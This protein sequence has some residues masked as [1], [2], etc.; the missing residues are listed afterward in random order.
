M[1]VFILLTSILIL[2]SCGMSDKERMEIATITCNVMAESR[3]MDAAFRIKELNSARE[4]LGEDRFLEGDDVIKQAFQFGLC[5]ELVLNDPR[6]KDLLEISI[7]NY[8]NEYKKVQDSILVEKQKELDS[9]TKINEELARKREKR[10]KQYRIERSASQKEWR[11]KIVDYL[12]DYTPSTI[13]NLRYDPKLERL[14]LNFA[15]SEKTKGLKA[16]IIIKFKN[17]LNDLTTDTYCYSNMIQFPKRDLSNE[18]LNALDK[19]PDNPDSIIESIIY[20]ISTVVLFK[21]M[22]YE[23]RMQVYKEYFPQSYKHLEASEKLDNPIV[24]KLKF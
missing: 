6:F 3:N 20:Q 22:T 17:G 19:V 12:D 2:S 14:S 16:Q 8:L 5:K 7:D 13:S 4:L 21:D 18:H 23:D 9:L 24:Y 11:S 10:L 1:R 15:C